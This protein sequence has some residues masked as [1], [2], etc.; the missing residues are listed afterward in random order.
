VHITGGDFIHALNEGVIQAY[1]DGYLRKSMVKNP[2]SKRQNTGDNTPAVVHVEI[3]PGEQMRIIALPKGGGAENMSR[4]IMLTPADGRNGII[5]SV[6]KT[7]DDAGPNPCGPVIV[8]VG[9]GGTAEKTMLM[10]KKALIR[11]IGEHHSD[12]EVAALEEEILARIN[13]LGIGPMGYGGRTTALA[14]NV[15]VFPA[16]IASLPVAVNLNCHSARHVEAIL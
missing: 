1:R 2:F 7:V 6:V 9:I 8:G 11:K 16:H 15:E 10:A 14:V 4:L 3:V 13:A 12:P 5:E